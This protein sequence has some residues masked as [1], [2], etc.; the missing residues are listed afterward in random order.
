MLG[1]KREE[2][3]ACG[4]GMNDYE[5]LSA[6]GFGVAMGNAMEPLK[7]IADYITETNDENGVAKAIEKFVLRREGE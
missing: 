5:M 6:V 3:M 2:I 7:E 4:D 1:I